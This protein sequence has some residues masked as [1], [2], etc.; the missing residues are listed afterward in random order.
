M[1]KVMNDPHEESVNGNGNGAMEID[2][3]LMEFI[4]DVVTGRAEKRTDEVDDFLSDIEKKEARREEARQKAELNAGTAGEDDMANSLLREI[5]GPAKP[6]IDSS[7]ADLLDG[8]IDFDTEGMEIQTS[9]TLADLANQEL[10]IVVTVDDQPGDSYQ[11]TVTSDTF[12]THF[13]KTVEKKVGRLYALC[14]AD[15]K[16]RQRIEVDDE[17][18]FFLF[19]GSGNLRLEGL[20]NEPSAEKEDMTWSVHDWHIHCAGSAQPKRPVDARSGPHTVRAPPI[21]VNTLLGNTVSGSDRGNYT[22]KVS[23]GMCHGE[24]PVS[25]PPNS[26]RSLH[27]MPSA[28][29]GTSYGRRVVADADTV[30]TAGARSEADFN[31]TIGGPLGNTLN[32]TRRSQVHI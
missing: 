18:S 6:E 21:T 23:Y 4:D 16:L 27:R 12:F 17:E 2:A 3:D 5:L 9:R 7:L 8:T 32:G 24:T 10:E 28:R 25:I 30:I 20:R 29:E 19:L 26:A 1:P 22:G 31:S 14:Y 15:P 11:F 13:R